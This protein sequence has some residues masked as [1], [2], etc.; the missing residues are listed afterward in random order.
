MEVFGAEIEEVRRRL[1]EHHGSV[2]AEAFWADPTPE[3]FRAAARP[4]IGKAQGCDGWRAR[5]M[6][7]LPTAIWAELC[8]LCAA[9]EKWGWPLDLR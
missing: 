6:C 1:E 2:D 3:Q 9:F 7:S 8:R 5:E 4:C